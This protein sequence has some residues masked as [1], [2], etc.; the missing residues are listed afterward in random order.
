[1]GSQSMSIHPSAVL[2]LPISLR[3]VERSFYCE[4]FGKKRQ[5][6]GRLPEG[7]VHK[8][9]LVEVD[10]IDEEPSGLIFHKPEMPLECRFKMQGVE[11]LILLPTKGIYCW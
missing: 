8:N 9:R 5:Q 1:M 10:L 7:P 4:S 11:S 3:N 2:I 6:A